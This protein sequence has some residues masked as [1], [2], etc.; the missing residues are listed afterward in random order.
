MA[1]TSN[2]SPL[3]IGTCSWK[4]PEWSIFP[5]GIDKKKFNFLENYS[6]HFNSVEIDQWFW[7]LFAPTKVR[8]PNP[9]D[10][11]MYATS[12]PDDFRFTI[13]APNAITLTHFYSTG[14]QAK[15]YPEHAGKENPHFLRLDLV[16]DFLKNL[17]PMNE[18]LGVIMFEF[19]YLN[20]QK[21]SGIDE[22]CE[23]LDPFLSALPKNFTFG[24]E[25]RNPNFLTK[26]FES[27]LKK[28]KISFVALQGYFMPNVWDVAKKIDLHGFKPLVIRFHGPDRSGIE[29]L[30]D[31]VW[32]RIAI[33]RS[34]D[35]ERLAEIIQ[36]SLAAGNAV[37]ANIN[38]H[39]EGC[40][41]LTIAKLRKLLSE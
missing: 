29:K 2:H 16:D 37:Y 32:N 40:A 25:L 22:F 9:K 7:S 12:V 3:Y 28:Y 34:A 31:S 23:R 14:S 5:D 39:F 36:A 33:D 38:N 20:K 24:I 15:Q 18:K 41:P 26:E 17:E 35:I 4:Y 19:E 10:V 6:K 27:L 11:E 13:K 30:T 21:M 8:M 1:A